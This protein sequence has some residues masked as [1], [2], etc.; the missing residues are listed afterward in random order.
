MGIEPPIERRSIPSVRK[1]VPHLSQRST[2]SQE[3]LLRAQPSGRFVAEKPFLRPRR[4]RPHE[5]REQAFARFRGHRGAR[6]HLEGHAAHLRGRG[7]LLPV[8][9]ERAGADVV[10]VCEAQR[11]RAVRPGH[12]RAARAAAVCVCEGGGGIEAG[13]EHRRGGGHVLRVQQFDERNARSVHSA[14][15]LVDVRIVRTKRDI[16]CRHAVL[17]QLQNYL[18]LSLPDVAAH[19]VAKGKA[20]DVER[21]ADRHA[22]LRDAMAHD[23][24]CARIQPRRHVPD[25]GFAAK[26]PG[27]IYVY[28]LYRHSDDR[29]QERAIAE[30]GFLGDD[31]NAAEL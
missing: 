12:E 27:S 5:Q 1:R 18:D 17:E 31:G 28:A 25:L 29:E 22:I 30:G 13:S 14:D 11:G 20:W 9:Q 26:R 3:Q 6:H 21:A 24:L 23:A 19:L 4:R 2:G 8:Q 10:R 7:V 16:E 15:G